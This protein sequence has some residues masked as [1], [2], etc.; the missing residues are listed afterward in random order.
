M[1]DFTD[2]RNQAR[3]AFRSLNVSV[4]MYDKQTATS[5]GVIYYRL[6]VAG[7]AIGAKNL[8]AEGVT[9]KE[10]IDAM[11]KKVAQARRNVRNAADDA[12]LERS[13]C[14]YV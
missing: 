5:S 1:C 6:E 9:P 14:Q 2:F 10:V 12:A 11:I 3:A 13:K 4:M 8:T 7:M